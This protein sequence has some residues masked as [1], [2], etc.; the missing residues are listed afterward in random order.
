MTRLGRDYRLLAAATAVSTLGDG[1][2]FAAMPLLAV[3]LTRD[4]AQVALVGAASTLP[5]LLL[6][7]P[8]GLWVDRHHRVRAMVYADVARALLA[9]AATGLLLAHRLGLP[10]LVAIAALMG[11]GEVVFDCAAMAVLPQLVVAEQL[12]R[13]NGRLYA[14]QTSG[15]DLA[16]VVLGA[17]LYTL[18]RALPLAVDAVS[19]VVS[20]AL[21]REVS[22]GDAFL[23]VRASDSVRGDLWVGVRALVGEPLL[24]TFTLV[25]VVVNLVFLGQIAIMAP[26]VATELRLPAEA[27]GLFL[28]ASAAGGVVGGV[29]AAHLRTVVGDAPLLI[30]SLLT[31]SIASIVIAS[32]QP[33]AAAACLFAGG[34]AVAMY[35]VTALSLR[36]SIVGPDRLGRVT[37]IYRTLTWGAMPAGATAFGWA[38]H[39]WGLR[40]PFVLGGALVLVATASSAPSTVRATAVRASSTEAGSPT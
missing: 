25:A 5:W 22:G 40:W 20:A 30:G 8:A 1:M 3:A 32:A 2:R 7:V 12:H 16:G 31:Q 21:L 17:A 24:V 19:F 13:A 18:Q 14:I 39:L 6:G 35:S 15:R 28:A 9:G 11:S 4:P 10:L 34:L 26:F 29:A 37:G 23:Q 38:A 33:M 27:F 36:Q